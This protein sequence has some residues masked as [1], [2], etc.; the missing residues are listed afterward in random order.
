MAN[1]VKNILQRAWIFVVYP[2]S[3]PDNWRDYLEELHV[4]WVESPLH[5]FDV[6]PTGEV[7]KPH[8]H[9]IINFEG[10]KSYS[11]VMDMIAPLNCTIPQV[12]HS[13]RGSV[14]YFAHLDNPEKYQYNPEL[15]VAHGGFN[16]DEYLK[17]S[18]SARYSMLRDMIQYI[19]EKDICDFMEFMEYAME[20]KYETWFPLLCDN[21]TYMIRSV[22][23]ANAEFKKAQQGRYT[24]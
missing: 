20:E 10:K 11:Q 19:R 1:K 8:W 17:L 5:E 3:A 6:N 22:I 4:A 16:A 21:S 9:V 14:R 24:D 15:I 12:C 7:K 18:A 13:I 2:E 23:Q